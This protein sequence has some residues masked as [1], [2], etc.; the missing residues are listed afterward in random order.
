MAKRKKYQRILLLIIILLTIIHLNG[1][2][3][4]WV[5]NYYKKNLVNNSS[6]KISNNQ[7]II[8]EFAAKLT[9]VTKNDFY[10][11]QT[12]IKYTDYFEFKQSIFCLEAGFNEDNSVYLNKC[13]INKNLV[14]ETY[15]KKTNSIKNIVFFDN[16]KLL[17]EGKP[18]A[19]Y[20]L[21]NNLNEIIELSL[22][23]EGKINYYNYNTGVTKVIWDD[24]EKVTSF[25][26]YLKEC[27]NVSE[28]AV[29]TDKQNVYLSQSDILETDE[30]TFLKTGVTNPVSSI[31]TIADKSPNS[32]GKTELYLNVSD[33][34]YQLD[35]TK[36]LGLRYNNIYPYESYI[37][38]NNDYLYIFEN[39]EIAYFVNIGYN[40][41]TYNYLID[42]QNQR[43]IIDNIF[44]NSTDNNTNFYLLTTSNKLYKSTLI[45]HVAQNLELVSPNVKDYKIKKNK[46]KYNIDITTDNN[47][48]NI[49][50]CIVYQQKKN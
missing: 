12:N 25:I 9:E 4:V 31:E 16:S 14:T 41:S 10:S 44:V 33:I 49:E 23:N 47:K 45:N 17:K 35:D 39:K 11:Q 48:L 32:C 5:N 24:T 28:I 27:S 26:I 38:L 13:Y 15:G 2:L 30:I 50:D 1:I 19:S 46:D 21:T 18:Q 3:Y 43:L 37:G 42:E 20:I 40:N 29:L 8:N 6:I 34:L 36:H 22:T 7:A